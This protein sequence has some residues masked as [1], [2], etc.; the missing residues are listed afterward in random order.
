MLTEAWH[1]LP[2][3]FPTV[4]VDMF[5]IMPNHIH[6]VLDL[7]VPVEG[8]VPP[9]LSAVIGAY[10]SITTVDWI[11]MS[12]NSGVPCSGHLWQ[13]RFYDHVIRDDLDLER[14]REYVLNNPLNAVLR[15]GREVDDKTWEETLHRVI[16]EFPFQL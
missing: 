15:R 10:K 13:K 16:K 8:V 2:N 6:G 11:R 9:S 12:K 7:Y 1:N 5:V 3:R 14:I 4:T